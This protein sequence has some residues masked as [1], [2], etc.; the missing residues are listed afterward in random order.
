MGMAFAPDSSG[1][2]I[3]FGAGEGFLAFSKSTYVVSHTS[4]KCHFM[5]N[6]V[7]L[8]VGCITEIA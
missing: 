6:V 8:E 4:F 5:N 7:V 2:G 1:W 3:G